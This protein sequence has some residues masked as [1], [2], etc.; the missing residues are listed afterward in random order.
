MNIVIIEDEKLTAQDLQKTILSILPNAH[1]VAIISSVEEGL[2]FFSVPTPIDLIFSD[3]QLG[4]GLSFELFEKAQIQIPIIFCT[5]YDEY[6]LKAFAAFGVDYI[7][8]PFSSESVRKAIDKLDAL[9]LR[10][11]NKEN[12][13]YNPIF[14]AI[15]QQLAPKTNTSILVYKGDKI[16]PT[17]IS[18]IAFFHIE[19]ETVYAVTFDQTKLSTHYKLDILEQKFYPQFFRCNRQFLV[20]RKAIK[21]ASQHFHR[22]LQVHLTLPFTDAILV[23]KE[24][25]T[26]FLDWLQQ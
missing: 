8:K 3:I 19:N 24:K 11:K 7:L 12:I 21:E 10:S 23:G 2:D 22:K 5:A 20:N 16:I 1:I 17:D 18:Q 25:V 13:D 6:A 26:A 15:K 4:D 14:E 9:T